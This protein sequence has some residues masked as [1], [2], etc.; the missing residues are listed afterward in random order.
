MMQTD[1]DRHVMLHCFK[2][3]KKNYKEKYYTSIL[4]T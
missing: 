1:I 2:V 4:Y 3:L